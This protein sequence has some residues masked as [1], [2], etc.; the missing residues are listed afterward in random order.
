[1]DAPAGIAMGHRRLSIVDVSETGAQPMVSSNGRMVLVYNGEIYNH[2]ALRAEVDGAGWNAGWRGH[3]DTE[4]LLAA[5][6]VWGISKTLPK[7]NGM[8][9]FALWDRETRTLCLARDRI[10]EKPLYYG[11][12]GGSFVFASELKAIAAFP[13]WRGEVDRDVL[14]LYLRYAYVPDPFCIWRGISRLPP[15]HWVEIQS[16]RA[17]E[18]VAYWDFSSVVVTPKQAV[19]PQPRLDRSMNELHH[20]LQAAVGMRMDADV[21]LGAFLSGGIDSSLIVALM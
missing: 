15:A 17:G 1:V 18:P 6:Q 4:T 20:R 8:F 5:L 9:A 12:V 2:R 3:S 16:G 11:T 19:A 10:G 14:A 7:L 13:N 21:P